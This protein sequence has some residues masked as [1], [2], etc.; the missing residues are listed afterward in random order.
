MQQQLKTR[1]IFNVTFILLHIIVRL[2]IMR[3][4]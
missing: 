4:L 3:L 1:D 2:Q